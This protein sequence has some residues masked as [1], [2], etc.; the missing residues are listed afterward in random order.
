MA[1][2]ISSGDQKRR[3]R[4][5]PCN[6]PF[7]RF[8]VNDVLGYVREH[9]HVTSDPH[10]VVVAGSSYG[11]LAAAYIALLHSDQVGNV[12]S[13]SGAF[14]RAQPKGDRNPNYLIRQYSRSELLPLRFYLEVGDQEDEGRDSIMAV[15]RELDRVLRNKGYDVT[16]RVFKGA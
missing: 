5:L 4:E 1:V 12:L 8:V 2:F 11:G 6:E 3:N 9:F 10:D 13:Q 7:A 15:N 14:D 16:L